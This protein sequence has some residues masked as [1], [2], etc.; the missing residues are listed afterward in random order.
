MCLVRPS[1]GVLGLSK[2]A[3]WMRPSCLDGWFQKQA[4][5]WAAIVREPKENACFSLKHAL[6]EYGDQYHEPEF[7]LSF[8]RWDKY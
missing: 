8:D 5:M 1:Q 7:V 4:L 6:G 3:L 2:Y